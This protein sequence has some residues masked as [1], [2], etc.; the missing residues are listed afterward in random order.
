[1]HLTLLCVQKNFMPVAWWMPVSKEP[2]KFLIAVDPKNYTLEL[3]RTYSEA[4][5]CFLPWSERRWV[6]RAGYLSGRDVDESKKL[7][8]DLIPARK[9]RHTHLPKAVGNPRENPILFLGYRDFATLGEK[10]R[11]KV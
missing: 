6:V 10:W 5:L 9:L 3:L 11:F 8:V 1:M 2:F 7:K 4:C